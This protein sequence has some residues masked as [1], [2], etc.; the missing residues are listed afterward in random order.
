ML[1]R[2]NDYNGNVICSCRL[3][4][5][6]LSQSKGFKGDL[7]LNKEMDKNGSRG[8]G[9]SGAVFYVAMGQICLASFEFCPDP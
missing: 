7:L 5:F 8:R 4:F 3:F 6:F 1:W 2:I 9:V